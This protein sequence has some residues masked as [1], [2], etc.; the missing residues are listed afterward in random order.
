MTNVRQLFRQSLLLTSASLRTRYRKTLAGLLW[1]VL[2]PMLVFL[3][4]GLIFSRVLNIDIENYP[5]FLLL[6]LLPWLFLLTSVEMTVGIIFNQGRM[7]KA[8]PVHPLSLVTSQ[9]LDSFLNFVISFLILLVAVAWLSG[10]VG[11]QLGWIALAVLPLVLFVT[12]VS[13]SLSILQVFL[14]DVRFVTSFALNIMFFMTPIFYPEKMVPPSLQFLIHYNPLV[15]ILRPF[16]L[17]NGSVETSAYL[18]SLAS[19]ALVGVVA[20]CMGIFIWK[21]A[22]NA[23]YFRI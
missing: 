11:H 2:S 22:R 16:Q 12:G 4:Q 7:L 9:I 19:A 14:H 3:I 20:F 6:G 8:F 21:R 13:F 1:V 10:T 15:Y 23:I 17:L 18:G 5:L